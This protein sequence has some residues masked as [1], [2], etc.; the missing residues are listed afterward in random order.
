MRDKIGILYLDNTFTFG[1]AINSLSYLIEAL[2]KKQ[3]TPVVV[4]GQQ[5]KLLQEK[6]G[7]TVCYHL[8]PKLTWVDNRVYSR[9]ASLP[10]FKIRI[11]RWLLNMSRFLYWVFLVDF[12]EALLFWRIGKKHGVK[13]VHLN[14]IMGSQLSGI[15]A[16]K[17]LGVP[18]V[19]HLR[20]FEVN[21]PITRFYAR[22]IDRHIAISSAI[23]ENLLQLGVAANKITVV[24]DAINIAEFDSEVACTYL[25]NEFSLV[26]EQP[27]FGIFGRVIA[28]KGIKEFLLAAQEVIA[29]IPNAHGFVVGGPSDGDETYYQEMQALAVELGLKG[30]VTFTGYRKDIPALMKFMDLIV[31]ASTRAEPFGMVLIEGMAMG[32]P[33]VATRAG[34]PMDIVVD[35]ETGYLIPIGDVAALGDAVFSLLADQDLRCRMGLQGRRKVVSEFSSQRYALQMETIYFDIERAKHG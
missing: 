13:L 5:E 7:G 6:F 21:H 26:P 18:C 35:G 11:V 2:D 17:L 3:F 19:A 8:M 9:I 24:H 1:G 15:M 12:P 4:T 14:N 31:H 25:L 28:W 29:R 10:F 34:G 20:D 32:K 23:K 27:K 33:V 30:K 16:A 22:L